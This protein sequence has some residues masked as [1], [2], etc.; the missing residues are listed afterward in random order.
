[1]RKF[2]ELAKQTNRHG[3]TP[4]LIGAKEI[5]S[6]ATSISPE[7]MLSATTH[8]E[9]RKR[10]PS[11]RQCMDTVRVQSLKVH[12]NT[13]EGYYFD[14]V[15]DDESRVALEDERNHVWQ[16]L[17]SIHDIP[18]G[19][20]DWKRYKP[21]INLAHIPI[22]VL[23]KETETIDRLDKLYS[24]VVKGLPLE[25]GPAVLPTSKFQD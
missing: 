5:V 25:L 7:Q 14:L 24:A 9:L 18:I 20:S 3:S 6:Q 23:E 19:S 12:S 11:L 22:G 15:L 8:R 10:V 4:E 16:A 13:E 1:M 21:S 2:S 17:E